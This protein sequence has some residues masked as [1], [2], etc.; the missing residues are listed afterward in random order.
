MKNGRENRTYGNEEKGSQE[1]ETL[2][3]DPKKANTGTREASP[4]FCP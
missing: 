1:K 2:R 3:A 4:N